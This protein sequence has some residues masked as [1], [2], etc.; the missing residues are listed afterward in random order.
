M[1]ATEVV[2]ILQDIIH[3]EGNVDLKVEVATDKSIP[4]TGLWVRRDVKKDAP[5]V[6]FSIG[7]KAVAKVKKTVPLTFAGRVVGE[8]NIEDDATGSHVTLGEITD[9]ALKKFMTS[10]FSDFS[11]NINRYPK[12]L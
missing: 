12:P 9:T 6:V 10:E 8:V 5:L 3:H 7:Q 2:A 4:I 1:K 11:V